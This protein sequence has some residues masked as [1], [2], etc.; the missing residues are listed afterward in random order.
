M[1]CYS[2]HKVVGYWTLANPFS[3][4][5]I[6]TVSDILEHG[7]P[8]RANRNLSSIWSNN[9][10][11]SLLY[12]SWADLSLERNTTFILYW[13]LDSK[14]LLLYSKSRGRK[15]RAGVQY[16]APAVDQMPNPYSILYYRNCHY[17]TWRSH[18][19]LFNQ[20]IWAAVSIALSPW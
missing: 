17:F 2:S 5:T 11:D 15:G 9:W 7:L 20:L 19:K 18:P 10:K 14:K 13:V 4:S 6:F 8:D 1:H 12:F 3:L 16:W